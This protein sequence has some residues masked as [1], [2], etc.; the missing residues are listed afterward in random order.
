MFSKIILKFILIFSLLIFSV[1]I[2]ASG[3]MYP[4]SEIQKI[5]AQMKEAGLNLDVKDIYNPDGVSLVDALVKLS[6]CTGFFVSENGLILTNHH[7]AFGAIN[8]ASTTENNYLEDGFYAANS[9]EEYSAE[10]YTARIT[11]SYEDVSDEVLKEASDIDDPVER[12]KNIEDKIKNLEEKFTN[13]EESIDAKVSEMF[14]GKTYILFKYK[15]IKDVRLVY[16]PPR[17]IGE[18]GGELD[19]WVWPRHTGDFSFMRAYVAPDGSSAEYSEENVPFNPKKYLRIN[20]NG[21]DKG[22]FVFLLGYPGRTYKNRS[23]YYLKY[24]E[25]YLLPYLSDLDEYRI[26]S[27]TLLGEDDPEFALESQSM[28][29]RHAN[30]MKNYRGKL[31]GLNN[32]DLVEKKVKEEDSLQNFIKENPEL[33]KKYGTLLSD[34]E[35]VYAEWYEVAEANIWFNQI[36]RYSD[37]LYLADFLLEFSEQTQLPDVERKSRFR[38]ENMTETLFDL[39]ERFNEYNE[40]M[41]VLMLEKLLTDAVTFEKTKIE[42]I[43]AITSDP[44]PDGGILEF[45]DSTLLTSDLLDQDYFLNLIEKNPEEISEL[46]NPVIEFVRSLREQEEKID[47]QMDEIDGTLDRLQANLI[48][49]KREWKESDFIPDANGTLRLTFGEVKGYSPLDAVFYEPLSSVK[50][51]IEKNRSGYN[52]YEA[53]EKLK[54]LYE[55]KAFGNYYDEEVNGL[56]VGTFV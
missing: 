15:I 12:K 38:E 13:D 8:N 5:E 31:K 52:E 16:A 40:S 29:K 49:V 26:E 50:G 1:T 3:G 55:Q 34:L 42:A 22:D 23:S 7:C 43:E 18:F 10:G 44:A 39:N 48:D 11:L 27:L 14:A 30:R 20:K 17:S 41:E 51:I 36:F 53:P 32:L 9:E 2:F 6:G 45:I 47:R 28:I 25:N 46:D 37:V 35:N 33:E 24:Q 54:E 4:L 19:N 56:P 21:A